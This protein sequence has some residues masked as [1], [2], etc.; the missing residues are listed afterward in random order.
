MI[1]ERRRAPYANAQYWGRYGRCIVKGYPAY[2]AE[3]AGERILKINQYLA[4]LW[5][6]QE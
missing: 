5:R 1:A 3:S 6:G 4:K 2:T